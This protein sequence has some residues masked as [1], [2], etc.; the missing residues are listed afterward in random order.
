[1]MLPTDADRKQE[2]ELDKRAKVIE[3]AIASGMTKEDLAIL[4]IRP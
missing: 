3:K 1:M 4:G 2:I